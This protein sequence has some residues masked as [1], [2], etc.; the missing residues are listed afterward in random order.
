MAAHER[1]TGAAKELSNRVFGNRASDVGS[2]GPK[3]VIAG[4]GSGPHAGQWG[5]GSTHG[6]AT[7]AGSS[8]PYRSGL[9]T[10]QFFLDM[11]ADFLAGGFATQAEDRSAQQGAGLNSVPLL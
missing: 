2:E 11:L 5:K 8:T 9:G 6:G 4:A 7:Q 3:D 10:G 1:Q